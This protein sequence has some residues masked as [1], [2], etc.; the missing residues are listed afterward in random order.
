MTSTRTALASYGFCGSHR[1]VTPTSSCLPSGSFGPAIA[2]KASCRWLS[3]TTATSA[4]SSS[5]SSKVLRTSSA[6]A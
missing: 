6:A 3:P 2:S 1:N 5:V 4:S